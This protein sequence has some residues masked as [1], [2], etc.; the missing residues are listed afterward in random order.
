[1]VFTKILRSTAVFNIDIRNIKG[2]L[3]NHVALKA[4][5][6]AAENSVLPSEE[7]IIYKY[8]TTGA[9]GAVNT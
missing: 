2:F 6:M 3:G 9:S 4:R 7:Y 1:M 5:V 8:I